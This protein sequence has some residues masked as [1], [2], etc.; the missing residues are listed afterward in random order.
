V[1]YDLPPEPPSAIL[2]LLE[3]PLTAHLCTLGRDGEPSVQPINYRW[4]GARLYVST[5]TTRQK[6]RNLV[7]DPRVALSIQD[8]DDPLRYVEV[9]GR[10]SSI[11]PDPTEEH[12]I[13]IRAR[14]GG[15]ASASDPPEPDIVIVEI[16][17][18]RF[19]TF[20]ARWE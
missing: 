4:D 6:Y 10:V 2:D 7:R 19:G 15:E 13:A 20:H 9:R 16:T 1:S 17:P 18:V 5:K 8:P 3:R 11:E 12:A 14:Y